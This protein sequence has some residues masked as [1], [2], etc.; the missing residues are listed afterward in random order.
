MSPVNELIPWFEDAARLPAQATA[1]VLGKRFVRASAARISGPMIPATAQIGAS[2]PTDGGRIQAAQCVAGEAA[3]G[4]STWDAATGEGFDII[5]EGVV[6]ITTGVANLAAGVAVQSDANGAAILL[7][8]GT[9]LGVTVDVSLA[10][11]DSQVA[12]Q[13]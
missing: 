6:P 2:D 13:L 11:A 1:P 10:G 3:L 7:A 4:V 12:L 9:K 5:R 8:A